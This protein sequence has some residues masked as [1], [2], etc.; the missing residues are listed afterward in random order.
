[1]PRPRPRRTNDS[2][3][4]KGRNTGYLDLSAN[5]PL[6]DKLTLNAHVGYT[7]YASDLRNAQTPTNSLGV[8]NFYD[9][10]AGVT[11][12]LGQGFSAAA[13]LVGAN[14][15]GFYGDFNKPR[16]ILTISKTM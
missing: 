2:T 1:M 4:A 11:Y 12:D 7:R 5:Y 14:K 8:P 16:A 9:Y 13:A 15:S 10:K 3:E 6:V